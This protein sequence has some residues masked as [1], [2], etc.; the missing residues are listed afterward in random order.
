M[1]IIERTH[2]DI[3]VPEP[4][5][6]S[7]V[8]RDLA[9]DILGDSV[10]ERYDVLMTDSENE[11]QYIIVEQYTV[12]QHCENMVASVTWSLFLCTTLL[13]FGLIRSL[14]NMFNRGGD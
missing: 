5:S 6:N 8:F 2:V 12:K 10:L 3:S 11:S 1:S 4:T 9:L 13:I 14:F 7:N